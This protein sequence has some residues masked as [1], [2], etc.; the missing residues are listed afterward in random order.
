VRSLYGV[1]LLMTIAKELSRYELDL[2]EV[3]EPDG[4][5]VT[6]NGQASAQH[7]RS[8]VRDPMNELF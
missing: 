4:T 7:G 1:G 8:R 2:V 6:Q 5:E 3:Q